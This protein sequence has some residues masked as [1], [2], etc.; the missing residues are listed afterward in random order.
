[1][2]ST[3]PSHPDYSNLSKAFEEVKEVNHKIN[4]AIREAE[5]RL[6]LLEISRSFMDNPVW[7][8]TVPT[9]RFVLSPAMREHFH[10]KHFSYNHSW[11]SLIV[12][13]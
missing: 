3:D 8:P 12:Y 10:H 11:L 4:E 5:N 13:L 2:K 1:M 6:K 9:V 7:G